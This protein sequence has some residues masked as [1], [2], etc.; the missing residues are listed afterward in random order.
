MTL[1]RAA[2]NSRKS[3]ATV[4]LGDLVGVHPCLDIKYGKQVHILPFDDSVEG[5]SGNISM[6]TSSPS[7]PVRK[8]DTFL[9]RGGMCT[10]EFKVMETNPAEFCIVAQDTGDPVKREDEEPNLNVLVELPLR[11][12]QWYKFIGT[13]SPRSILMFGP[14]GTGKTLIARAV[15]NETGAFSFLIKGHEVTSKMATREKNSP[16]IIFIDEVDSIAP[17]RQ[18]TNGEVKRPVVL[19][20]LTL[21]DGLKARSNVVVKG[22]TNRPNFVDPGLCRL[23][24]FDREDIASVLKI[25]FVSHEAN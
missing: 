18:K 4:K 20:L 8:G 13:K 21:I 24:R 14:P 10:V 9:V 23:G 22:A 16:A 19:Q 11:R 25:S 17:K 6:S 15:A 2:Y 7:R 1:K 3:L 5:L 12:P